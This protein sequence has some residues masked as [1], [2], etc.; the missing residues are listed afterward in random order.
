MISY[1]QREVILGGDSIYVYSKNTS[2]LITIKNANPAESEREEPTRAVSGAMDYVNLSYNHTES[3]F[4]GLHYLQLRFT[5]EEA[6]EV[7][8]ELNVLSEDAYVRTIP[9]KDGWSLNVENYNQESINNFIQAFK[10]VLVY[11]NYLLAV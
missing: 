3:N 11:Y 8:M 7:Y 1:R 6:R 10:N 5:Y 2:N 9:I 4:K